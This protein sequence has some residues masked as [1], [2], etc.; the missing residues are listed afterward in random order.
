MA[1]ALLPSPAC[2]GNRAADREIE[3]RQR[4]RRRRASSA[5]AVGDGVLRRPE[6]PPSK[7]KRRRPAPSS[8]TPTTSTSRVDLQRQA[9]RVEA[10]AEVR[11]RARH[12]QPQPARATRSRRLA[13]DINPRS[14]GRRALD[15]EVERRDLV[16][17]AIDQ[18]ARAGSSVTTK[19]SA[20]FGPAAFLAAPRRCSGR[21]GPARWRA[22][23]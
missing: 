3:R 8:L 22:R 18:L 10:R 17:G 16:D 15:V 19:G 11:G 5:I 4:D 2:I 1:A 14:A 6:R 9:E 23:R 21:A 20:S 12:P 7:S 13:T